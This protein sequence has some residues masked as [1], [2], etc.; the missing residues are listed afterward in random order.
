MTATE[1]VQEFW[2]A[3]PPGFRWEDDFDILFDVARLA[4]GGAVFHESFIAKWKEATLRLARERDEV[5]TTKK[6]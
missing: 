5:F 2:N 6:P 4:D 1:A 3:L